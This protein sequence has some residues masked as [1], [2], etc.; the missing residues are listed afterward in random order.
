MP[1][2]VRKCLL[3]WYLA[4]SLTAGLPL[5]LFSSPA[6][7]RSGI[8]RS[9]D[10]HLRKKMVQ[11]RIAGLELA[12]IRN[13]KLDRTASYGYANLDFNIPVTPHTVF[14]VASIT[15]AITGIAVMQL[16]ETGKLNLDEPI[17][18]YLP[19]L[20]PRWRT[21]TARQLL[22]H[23]SGL[24]D[25][26]VNSYT[27]GIIADTPVGHRRSSTPSDAGRAIQDAQGAAPAS[28]YSSQPSV[29]G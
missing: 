7:A 12:V 10:S 29:N 4:L 20:P 28:P 11:G 24:P 16:V 27:T 25:I 15:K 17:A 8:D 26:M 2:L 21:V 5:L 23:T 18:T 13:G 3:G 14:N 9:V 22:S 6:A 19:D 1:G